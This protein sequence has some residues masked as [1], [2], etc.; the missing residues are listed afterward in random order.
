MQ[1]DYC[2]WR[3][4]LTDWKFAQR[5]RSDQLA[6]VHY[7]SMMKRHGDRE[8]EFIITVREYVTPKDPIML[9]FATAD[10]QTN[11]STTPYTPCGW[12]R[13]LLEALSSCMDEVRRFPYEPEAVAGTAA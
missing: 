3:M 1:I 13:T 6:H 8:T 10:K 12:G 7:F 4:F 2:C 11:Q 9:F 5:D